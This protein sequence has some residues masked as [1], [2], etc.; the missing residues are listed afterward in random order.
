MENMQ[1]A[2][3]GSAHG[4]RSAYIRLAWMAG[5]SFVAMYFLMYA[6]VDRYASVYANINQV[7]MAGLMAA[8]MVAIELLIMGA[9]Y[10][11]RR[12]NR[13]LVAT[14]VALAVLFWVL[15]RTQAGVADRQFL[16][17]MIPHHSGAILM[18]GKAELADPE[19]QALCRQI[20]DSQKAEI[21]LMKRMLERS[22]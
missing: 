5:L 15:I 4:G 16:R 12:L 6:M 18:C 13:I 8:P 17:S 11:D 21:E 2:G 3:G 22:T 19:L 20:I 7:Y 14:S 10:R 9:M 1:H